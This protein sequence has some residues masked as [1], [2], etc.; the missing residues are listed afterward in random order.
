[1]NRPCQVCGDPMETEGL[2]GTLIDHNGHRWWL[3]QECIDSLWHERQEM[4]LTQEF[5][6]QAIDYVLETL[7]KKLLGDDHE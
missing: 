1:M 2:K 4:V 7:R 6:E 5:V 3:C